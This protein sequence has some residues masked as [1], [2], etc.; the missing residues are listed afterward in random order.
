MESKFRASDPKLTSEM[1][2]YTREHPEYW[3][4]R[5]S[6]HSAEG[7]LVGATEGDACPLGP[8]STFTYCAISAP[9][10]ENERKQYVTYKG[11]ERS[12]HPFYARP[13]KPANSGRKSKAA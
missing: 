12:G 10:P 8:M 1:S 7:L 5:P 11:R 4:Q 2:P 13:L 9:T 3:R 6:D